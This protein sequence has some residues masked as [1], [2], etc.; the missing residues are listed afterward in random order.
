MATDVRG[1]LAQPFSRRKLLAA[2]G[3]G[4]AGLAVARLEGLAHAGGAGAGSARLL[5]RMQEIESGGTLTYGLS[6]DVDG[7]LDPGV[8]H[9]DTTIRV[10][11]NICEPLVW[12]PTATE[13]VP[14][15]AES[16][17][18]SADGLAYTFKLKQ[19]VK[20][21]DGTPFNAEAVQFSF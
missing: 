2:S 9:F 17:E 21:H 7:T 16:W 20:F 13:F 1:H 14:G 3:G 18:V 11:L 15:L 5:S 12:M 8:T 19:G 6:G 4:A 10:T